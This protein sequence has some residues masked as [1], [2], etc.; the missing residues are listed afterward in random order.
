MNTNISTVEEYISQFPNEVQ[1]ILHQVRKIIN[2]TAPEAQESISY[3]MPAYKYNGPLVYFGAFKNHIGFFALPSGHQAFEKELSKYKQGK[4]S[5]QFPYDRAIP[6]KLI[7]KIVKFR[8][9]ENKQKV[10]K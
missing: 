3:G 5:A 8:Y 2:A 6:L 10:K 9:A 1:G 4:G 7:E